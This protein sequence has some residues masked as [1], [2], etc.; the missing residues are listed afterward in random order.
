MNI[1]L[2]VGLSDCQ[3]KICKNDWNTTHL[4]PI[5]AKEDFLQNGAQRLALDIRT[6]SSNSNRQWRNYVL[7]VTEVKVVGSPIDQECVSANTI[8]T[9]DALTY[10]NKL[11]GSYILYRHKTL[12]YEVQV[13]F[14]RC[15][16]RELC[17]CSV[18]VRVEDLIISFDICSR[19]YIQVWAERI[20]GDII[21]H[22]Q[23]PKGVKLLSL[24]E[25][26][27]YEVYKHCNMHKT[28]F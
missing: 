10:S 9:F 5:R 6:S 14:R 15:N 24:D 27:S 11:Q 12:P 26:R 3:L 23:L 18:A 20:N 7:P 28:Y 21:A 2:Q 4:I 8:V 19:G 17:H 13:S 1:Y 25:G 16:L 22:T